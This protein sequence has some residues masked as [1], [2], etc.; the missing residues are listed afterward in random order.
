MKRLLALFGVLLLLTTAGSLFA[1]RTTGMIEG[2]VHDTEGTPLPGVN[3]TVAGLGLTRSMAT[4]LSGMYRFPALPPGTYAV[5]A[6]LVGFKKKTETGIVVGLEQ[7]RKVDFIL[8]AGALEEEITVVGISP[9]VDLSSSRLTTN[10]KKEFFDA[11]PKGR[12]YQDMVQLAPSVQTDP[13][14]AAMSGSTGAEN[15]YIIDGINTT[16]VEDGLVGT[17]LTYEFIEEVQVK[18]GG[19]EA[20]FA[21]ALG[22]VVNI[23]T[24]SGSNELHGGLVFNYENDAFYGT[25]LV[26]IFGAGAIDK[27]NYFDLGLNLSGAIIKDKAWFFLGGT[28]SFRNTTYTQTDSWTGV[29]ESFKEPNNRY[30]FSGKL[31][32]EPAA[33][34]K[35]TLSGFGDP[36][37]ADLN[38]PGTLRDFTTWNQYAVIKRTGGTYNVALKY[39][40]IFGN[41]W[42]IHVLGGLFYD[43]TNDIP[44]DTTKPAIY[45]EQGYLGAPQS[46]TFGGAGWYADPETRKRWQ[47]SGDITKF[48]GG[49]SF[50]AGVQ[51]Q[52]S[53]SLREDKYTGGY[54]RQIRPTS[55]YFRDRWRVTEGES[56]T[57]MMGLFVQDSWNVF[58]RLTVNFGVRFE[59]QNSHASDKSRFFEPNETII[60]F[61][62]LDQISPR[63]GFTFDILGNG[64]SKL[65]GS[66]GRFYEMMPLDMNNRQFGGEVDIQYYYRF[67]VGDPLTVNPDKALA[68][69]IYEAGS[70][71]SSFPEPDKANK[72]LDAQYVEEF[73]VGFENQFATDLSVS[74]RGVWK[75]LGMVIE[76]GSF[77]GGSTYFLFNPGRQF[78]VG[79]TNPNT[80]L[81]RELY[82]DGFP[83]AK[84]D[85]KALEIMLNKRFSNNYMFTASYTYAHLRGNHPGLAW[86]EYAQLDPNITAL[87]DFPEFLYNAEGILP[88]DRPH[89]IKLDGVYQF[90]KF[91]PGLTIG[92]SFRM[93][94]GK[95]LSK[96]GYNTYYGA[97]VTLTPRGSDGRL[98]MFHQLDLHFG[99]DF[100]IAKKYKIG[101]TFDLFNV[102]NARVETNRDLRYL[103]TVFWGTP[104]PLMPWDFNMTDYPNP[105]NDYYGHATTY[106]APIRGRLGVI[107]SF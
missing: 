39:D 3:V 98:P 83:E 58:D 99:Y 61:G 48:I 56:F 107:L 72:G 81:P 74:V 76:D 7:T 38:N 47:A 24:K 75:R 33:G 96:I 85:Y 87:F 27:F 97:C 52:R 20:E 50:K 103:R 22:G 79:Q 49:H 57:D 102:Y 62:L 88:G 95:T 63:L 12:S 93:N 16:D 18:T 15:L 55:N 69:R 35:I 43:K 11:L 42:I 25:P 30:Y 9:I 65:F 60:H 84:R 104:D 29:A 54:Y 37:K 82:I 31:T 106:Q 13:W 34:Q 91:I 92:A 26:G 94:S 45:L 101:I 5:S 40:G 89:Q 10:V 73:I 8:E 68:Y 36:L 53:T 19:Y 2:T 23:I 51:W 77:D 66:Y 67:T 17:N 1:Q 100:K 78:A 90:S 86:E 80:G 44:T 59:D 70:S 32:F 46:Y 71:A 105:D 21:G 6:V 41:D 28:P 4:E 14:G 64:T